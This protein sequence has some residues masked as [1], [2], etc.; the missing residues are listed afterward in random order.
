MYRVDPFQDQ[1]WQ[2]F[3]SEH[4]NASIFHSP[5]WL[6]A[7][8]RTY[9]YEPFVVTTS[10]PGRELT[11]GV[12]FCRIDSRLTGRRWVSLP[13]SDHCQPL[14]SGSEG[15]EHLLSP[16]QR[17]LK[18]E[19]CGYIEIRPLGGDHLQ[20]APRFGKAKWFWFHK[21]DLRPALDEIVGSFHKDCVQRK[22]RRAEREGLT[23]EQGRSESLL[24]QF[25]HLLL[26]T[27]RRHHLPPHPLNWFVNLIDCLGQ[28]V[29]I[30]VASKDGR[31]VA[32]A[33]TLRYKQV[34]VYKYGCSNARYNH[35]GGMQLLFW[36]SIEEAKRDGFSEFDLGR[37]DWDN[38]GLA[39]FKDRW[40][41]VRSVLTYWRYPAPAVG[42]LRPRWT[43]R[44]AKDAL[45]HMPA[46][47]LSVAGKLLYRHVG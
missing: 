17:D 9:G 5:E 16:L 46:G 42:N 18:K 23:Y 11:D 21:I 12:V 40:G 45:A 41:G 6:E 19:N 7:L 8:R 4:P 20:G 44:L 28:H 13:F 25:Y 39:T 32:S 29:E 3:L 33:L 38:P 24:K 43:V 47:L 26:L 35:L 31:P 2:V 22:I 10:A 27:R 36:R 37:S 14:V 34:L 15:L 1:R 30:R